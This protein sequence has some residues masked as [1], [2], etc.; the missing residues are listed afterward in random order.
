MR[1]S[2]GAYYPRLDHVRALAA[3]LVFFWH[4][5]R[6]ANSANPAPDFFPLSIF[7]QGWTGVALFMT[8]AGYL[9]AKIVDGKQ[10]D[11]SNFLFNRLIRL[12]PLLAV[13]F[14]YY[15]L[16]GAITWTD[17]LHGVYN[18][19]RWFGP[20]WSLSV[21]IQFYILFP[22]LLLLQ[23]RFGTTALASTLILSIGT[24]FAIWLVHGEVQSWAYST[25]VGCFDLFLLGMVLFQISK[26]EIVAKY[27]PWIFTVTLL[28]FTLFWHQ[29]NPWG[30]FPPPSLLW[31]I[32]PT[33]QG[34]AWGTLLMT[35]EKMTFT[36]PRIIDRM[37]ARIGEV[38]Y[39]LYLWHMIVRDEFLKL[40]L[41]DFPTDLLQASL[42]TCALFV[43]MV[44][45]AMLSFEIFERPFLR[46]R[47]RYTSDRHRIL[48]QRNYPSPAAVEEAKVL[49]SHSGTGT[50]IATAK[51]RWHPI[52]VLK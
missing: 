1:S 3:F 45:I 42:L 11:Y 32:L 50:V 44:A 20:P 30:G 25:I 14:A 48:R 12:G 21:E 36:M 24:R 17:I 43:P 41:F 37:L 29:F 34:A 22:F 15:L 33:I 47:L 38:S 52:F 19:A 31:I 49:A 26:S 40:H 7:Q 8:L 4:Y 23:R 28:A 10:I 18:S 2:S 13:V 46:L 39:S 5:S 6:I 27:A 51:R 35:Y 9:F 16:N